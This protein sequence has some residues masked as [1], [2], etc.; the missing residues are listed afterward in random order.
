MLHSCTHMAT[1]GVKWLKCWAVRQNAVVV[2][3]PPKTCR[4][5][6]ATSTSLTLTIVYGYT[7]SVAGCTNYV[8]A[9]PG[10][11]IPRHVPCWMTSV[12]F[13]YL[14]SNTLYQVSI[15]THS[16][17]SGQSTYCRTKSLRAWTCE[18]SS[19]VVQVMIYQ[20]NNPDYSVT[21]ITTSTYLL[22]YLLTAVMLYFIIM[23]KRGTSDLG[24]APFEEKLFKLPLGFLPRR[25]GGPNLKSLAQVVLKICSIVCQKF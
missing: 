13:D 24:H 3:F 6:L 8:V 4:V 5:S 23:R 20:L 18:I 9:M 22:T 21:G 7:S 1:V 11:P 12:H 10:M 17:F 25:S 19:H 2:S 16:S 15:V 14:S